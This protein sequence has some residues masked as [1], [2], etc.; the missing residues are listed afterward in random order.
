[1]QPEERIAAAHIGAGLKGSVLALMLHDIAE[2]IR[3]E[4]LREI[5]GARRVERS[6]KHA[7]PEYVRFEQPPV[8]E[9]LESI[10]LAGGERLTPQIKYYD[11]GVISVVLEFP[12]EC[13]WD[14]LVRLASRW[15]PSVELEQAALQIVRGRLEKIAPA[16]VRQ[17]SNW[18]NEDYYIFHLSAV[19]GSPSGL[20]L[21][22][23]RLPQIAQI[24]RGEQVPLSRSEY[25]DVQQASLS[26]EHV[27]TR[28]APPWRT[29]I[30]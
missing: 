14:G 13:N 23:E 5:L 6:F 15:V 12:F 4:P 26:F 22:N 25:D 17:Y 29:S 1:M 10:T 3:L 7:T 16:I 28:A 30:R 18:L 24:L 2:E 8:V 20:G 11:Y 27:A 9:Q 19:E 21:L